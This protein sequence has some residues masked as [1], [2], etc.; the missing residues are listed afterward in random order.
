MKAYS[1]KTQPDTSKT[2]NIDTV[3]VVTYNDGTTDELI[4]V[5][6]VQSEA[7]KFTATGSEIK[8]FV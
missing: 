3:I 1:W 6:T 2:G 4:I 7:E 5:L 8:K